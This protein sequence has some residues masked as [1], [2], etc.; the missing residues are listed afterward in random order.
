MRLSLKIVNTEI[1]RRGHNAL[2]E[3]GTGHFFFHTGEAAGWLDRTVRVRKLNE[4][5]LKQW[6]EEFRRLK[7][8][9]ERI[10]RTAA[11]PRPEPKKR[12][13]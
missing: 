8:L 10:L 13:G 3:K 11:G 6:M 2:L 7:E 12:G 5:T 9:N 1:A 4:L